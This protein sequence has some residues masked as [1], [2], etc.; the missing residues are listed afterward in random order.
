MKNVFFESRDNGLLKR[1]IPIPEGD[2]LNALEGRWKGVNCVVFG[3]I[4]IAVNG[5]VTGS[6]SSSSSWSRRPSATSSL[7]KIA[8]SVVKIASSSIMDLFISVSSSKIEPGG[9]RAKT[10]LL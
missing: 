8:S 4:P 3:L 10:I 7:S 5:R 2:R 6:F 1:V 9:N